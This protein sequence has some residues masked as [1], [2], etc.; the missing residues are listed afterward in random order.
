MKLVAPTVELHRSWLESATE[1][2]TFDQEGAAYHLAELNGLDL[3][4]RA[5]FGRW[6][7]LL[8]S[9]ERPE[10]FAPDSNFWLVEDGVYLGA[11]QL[12]HHLNSLQLR[13]LFGHIGYGVR[14]SSRGQGLATFMLRAVVWEAAVLGLRRVL[15]TCREDNAASIGVIRACGGVLENIRPVDDFARG[16]GMTTPIC[17][18]WIE[19]GA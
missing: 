7:E 18:F 19:T 3:R 15:V 4:D 5:D 9:P 10:G 13:E 16:W 17:Q 6:V 14:P 1:W 8:I 2:G 12:R 11:V